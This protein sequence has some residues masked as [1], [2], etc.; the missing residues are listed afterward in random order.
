MRKINMAY[1]LYSKKE[2][3]L[4]VGGIFFLHLL[5]IGLCIFWCWRFLWNNY[6]PG[7]FVLIF[8]F[9]GGLIICDVLLT[10]VQGLSRFL[11]RCKVDCTGIHCSM[12]F[13]KQWHIAWADIRT[14]GLLGLNNSISYAQ[15]F[16]STNSSIM[17]GNHLTILSDKRI[18]FQINSPLWFALMEYLPIDIKRKLL[19]ALKEG[20]DRVFTH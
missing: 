18:V 12:P 11:V 3:Y 5:V 2:T 19:K 14:Y 20:H 8:M 4:V 17:D 6:D 15:C 1:G 13:K 7:G 10:K 16:L 9:V